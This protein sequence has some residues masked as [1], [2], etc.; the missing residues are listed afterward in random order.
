[1][2]NVVWGT[3][4]AY[5]SDGDSIVEPPSLNYVV[6]VSSKKQSQR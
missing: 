4:E 5:G 3:L 6:V 2:T 1:M